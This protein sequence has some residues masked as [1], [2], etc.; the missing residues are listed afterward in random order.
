[1]RLE[2]VSKLFVRP[3][4]DLLNVLY[5]GRPAIVSIC[6]TANGSQIVTLLLTSTSAEL[7]EILIEAIRRHGVTLKGSKHGSR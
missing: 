7:K 5:S 3:L 4:P 2:E 1:M 6:Q